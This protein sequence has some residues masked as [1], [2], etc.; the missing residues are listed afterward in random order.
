LTPSVGAL[1]ASGV[2]IREYL[3]LAFDYRTVTA[4]PGP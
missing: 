1:A 2:A 3:A 4:K